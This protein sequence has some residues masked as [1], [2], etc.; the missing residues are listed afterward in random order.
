ML[1]SFRNTSP[2]RALARRHL[3]YLLANRTKHNRE[4]S[5]ESKYPLIVY[6]TNLTKSILVLLGGPWDDWQQPL[7]GPNGF[8]LQGPLDNN[9]LPLPISG[10]ARRH[11]SVSSWAKV[12]CWHVLTQLSILYRETLWLLAGKRG[13]GHQYPK[14]SRRNV[15]DANAPQA[16]SFADLPKV[17][18]VLQSLGESNPCDKRM[19]PNAEVSHRSQPP[20]TFDLFQDQPAGSGWLHRLVRLLSRPESCSATSGPELFLASQDAHAT[21][22][23]LIR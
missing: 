3:H 1:L 2:I 9:G 21:A 17:E 19:I 23:R 20:A 8:V 13:K 14:M 4:R 11:L 5:R 15:E 6:P 10:E 18:E 7:W 16:S 12:L 22:G